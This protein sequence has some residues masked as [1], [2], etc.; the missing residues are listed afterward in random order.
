[1]ARRVG[2]HASSSPGPVDLPPGGTGI[3]RRLNHPLDLRGGYAENVAQY[4]M[5]LGQQR[6][7]APF[8]ECGAGEELAGFDSDVPILE[9]S[10]QERLLLRGQRRPV[11]MY[12]V[13]RGIVHGKF[14]IGARDA[15]ACCEYTVF[16][17]R[18]NLS[19]CF[20]LARIAENEGLERRPE[21]LDR[22]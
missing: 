11:L 3:E 16:Y 9:C 2:E 20:R 13:E 18:E 12:L 17:P 22:E 19:R 8:V 5:L 14:R 10:A 15:P 4:F 21:T 7:K 6:S 1:M